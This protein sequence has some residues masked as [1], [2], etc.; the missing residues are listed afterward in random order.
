[1][2]APTYEPKNPAFAEQMRSSFEREPFK[3]GVGTLC[4][5]PSRP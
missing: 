1:M 4:A 5:T 3:V 2:T